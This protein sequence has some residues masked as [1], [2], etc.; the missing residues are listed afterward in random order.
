MHTIY[1]NEYNS[2]KTIWNFRVDNIEL[3]A[4]ML[5]ASIGILE[6]YNYR[7]NENSEEKVEYYFDSNVDLSKYRLAENIP[8]DE[9]KNNNVI[10]N[11]NTFGVWL[12]GNS[13]FSYNLFTFNNDKFFQGIMSI[14]KT[15]NVDFRT[16]IY[17]YPFDYL[18]EKY[19]VEGNTI[20]KPEIAVWA[21]SAIS[22]MREEQYGNEN[23]IVL[24]RKED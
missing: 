13:R 7:I 17:G 2:N 24:L 5:A 16:A 15:F 10:L 11:P 22:D 9:I 12:K 14:C 19:D 4:G 21:P 1:F 18:G 8:E 23:V 20:M 3:V 6:E